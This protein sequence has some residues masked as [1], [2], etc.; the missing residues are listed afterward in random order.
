MKS[1]IFVLVFLYT[2]QIKYCSSKDVRSSSLKIG[3]FNV[4]NLGAKKLNN[5]EIAEIIRNIILRYDV[6]LIQ[7]IVTRN[8]NLIKEFLNSVNSVAPKRIVYDMVL[9]KRLGRNKAKEQYAFFYRRDAV[10]VLDKMVY[11]DLEDK[12]MRPPYIVHFQTPTVE[13]MPSFI[14]IGI[15]TQPSNAA[16]ET[17]YLTDV[18][19]FAKNKYKIKDAMI[20]GDMN[21][22]CSSVRVRDWKNIRLRTRRDFI[23]LIGQNVDTTTNANTCPYD[24][25]VI[26]G[27]KI[28][29]A[30]IPNSAGIFNFQNAYKLTLEEA[31]DVSDHWPVEVRL[32]GKSRFT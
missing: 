32:K 4:Q 17:D 2:Y 8:Q 21:A 19:D 13:N 12:F 1:F 28:E 10:S 14:A 9:S 15:H 11:P 23:W 6:I 18:Y 30:I 5:E 26:A 25:I 22:G 24:R 31:R 27:E 20:M 29:S 3:A 16:N 7:E